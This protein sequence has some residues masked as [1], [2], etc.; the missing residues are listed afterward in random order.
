MIDGRLAQDC[1]RP[2]PIH[3]DSLT[4]DQVAKS[5]VRDRVA[6]AR[7]G[8]EKAAVVGGY[9]DLRSQLGAR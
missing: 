3:G 1:A 9:R 8:D 6:L 4:S 5:W 7:C 2:V